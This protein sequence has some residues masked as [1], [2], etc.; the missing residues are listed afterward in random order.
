[1]GDVLRAPWSRA[2]EAWFQ[3]R[4]N[5]NY[6]RSLCKDLTNRDQ[7]LRVLSVFAA[8]SGG[9]TT[10]LF[11]GVPWAAPVGALLSAVL[12]T[13]T[14]VSTDS[15]RARVA[16]GLLSQYVELEGVFREIYYKSDDATI[17]ELSDALARLDR[18]IAV[19]VE[20]APAI[21]DKRLVEADI[22][23]RTQFKTSTIS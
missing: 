20:R 21:D 15:E 17:Q 11:A 18:V 8:L 14:I 1:M 4:L 7:R 19:E 12:T 3:C 5:Q 23:T 6:Y 2:H 10:A 22:L 16:S 13:A 9:A